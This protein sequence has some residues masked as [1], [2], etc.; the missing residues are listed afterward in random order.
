MLEPSGKRL[1]V[2][3]TQRLGEQSR[4]LWALA[5]AGVSHLQEKHPSRLPREG[6]WWTSTG[7]YR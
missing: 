5:G 3:I 1:E 2:C 4:G 7:A 6:C